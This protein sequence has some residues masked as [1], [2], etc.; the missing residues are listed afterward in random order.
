MT[1]DFSL[2]EPSGLQI[3]IKLNT[4]LSKYGFFK[5]MDPEK[6]KQFDQEVGDLL[7]I[8][9]AYDEDKYSGCCNGC[10]REFPDSWYKASE[11]ED[12]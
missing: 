2:L 3:H 9:L 10:G 8:F 6:K 12:K 4:I 11:N 7:G 1:V 5:D